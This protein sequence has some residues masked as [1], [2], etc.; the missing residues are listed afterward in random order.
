VHVPQQRLRHAVAFHHH[1]LHLRARRK[2]HCS[3]SHRNTS[4]RCTKNASFQLVGFSHG[5]LTVTL[6]RP[7]EQ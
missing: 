3:Q 5:A 7:Q 2:P 4:G 1:R 6:A